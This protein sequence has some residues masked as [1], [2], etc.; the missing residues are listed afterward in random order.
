MDTAVTPADPLLVETMP[1]LYRAVVADFS[2]K[3]FGFTK[4]QL[5]VFLALRSYGC[6]TMKQTAEYLSSSKEQ[7]TRAVSPLVDEGY[8]ERY[9][10]EE[11]RTKTH[12][13]LTPMGADYI[14]N[15][16]RRFNAHIASTI[17]AH[18]SE[19]EQI[20]LNESLRTLHRLL[21]RLID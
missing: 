18:L 12:I 10:D 14:E 2:K 19:A 15:R 8:V 3:Q 6:L 5:L 4:S 16:V 13:R 17:Q 11:N 1:L 21:D 7:A 20:E 9:I